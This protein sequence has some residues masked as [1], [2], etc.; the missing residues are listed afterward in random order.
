MN[1]YFI[2][3]ERLGFSKWNDKKLPLAKKLWGDLKVSELIDSRGKLNDKQILDKLNCEIGNQEKFGVQYFPI[4][5]LENNEFVGCCGLKP[6][7]LENKIYE[8]GFHI[9]PKHWRKGIAK[10][11]AERIINYAFE[12]L[13]VNEIFAGHHPN[14][15][16]SEKLLKKLGFEFIG[17]EFF[18]P[19]GSNHPSYKIKRNTTYN[20]VYKT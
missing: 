5:L 14:N 6:Y 8:I 16:S 7:D 3:S 4:F 20:T 13:K 15:N 10:E 1:E 9:I 17:E 19:T 11:S 12:E 2:K 18:E